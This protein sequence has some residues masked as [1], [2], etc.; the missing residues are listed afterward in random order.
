MRMP[1]GLRVDDAVVA[2]ASAARTDAA[3]Q[4]DLILDDIEAWVNCDSPSADA[5]ALGELAA[6]IGSRLERYG[7]EV[8]VQAGEAGP[9]L[10]AVVHGWGR[11]RVALLCHHDTVFP[12]G[13][14]A[15]RPFARSGDVAR[16]PAVAD[17][18]G[19]IAVAAHV[20]RILKQ[21]HPHAFG[22]LELISVPDEEIRSV[23]FR[24]IDAMAGCDAVLGMECGRPGGAVVTARKGGDW[25]R[26]TARGRAAHAGV[27]GGHGRS[28]LLAAC[29][30]SLRIAELDGQREGLGVHVT[31]LQAGEVLNSVAA[32]AS[33][34]LDLRA[35]HAEDLDWALAEIARF[36]RHDSI[37]FAV[38]S[39]GRVP[40]L[41]RTRAVQRLAAL[42]AAIGKALGAPVPEVRT[43]GVSDACWTAAAG[44]PTLDGLGPTGAH[45]HTPDEAIAVPSIPARC[46]LVAGLIAAVEVGTMNTHGQRGDND[47]AS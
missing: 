37:E 1:V 36:G 22:R 21:A 28:A 19:G 23:P 30:E 7:A 16:G 34:M 18:K 26:V 24:G 15:E 46:G 13:T 27:A 44:I 31:M 43:G 10:R 29:R 41:E 12:R 4:L 25:L 42:A 45:D 8:T 9:A 14:A 32:S 11:C 39:S 40:P 3:S 6:L 33:M 5:D 38:S 20:L 35:W 17:M 2:V 47:D